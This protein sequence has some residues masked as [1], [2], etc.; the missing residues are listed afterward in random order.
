MA[1]VKRWENRIVMSKTRGYVA[2]RHKRAEKIKRERELEELK[3]L[4]AELE[5]V[6]AEQQVKKPRAKSRKYQSVSEQLS[7]LPKEQDDSSTRDDVNEA[8]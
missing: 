2:P 4:R 1:R 8:V 3:K 5:R 6:K 7:N